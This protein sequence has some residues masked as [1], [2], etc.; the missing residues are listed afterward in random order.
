MVG[1]MKLLTPSLL[2]QGA[3]FPL[4]PYL[5]TSLQRQIETN[6][7]CFDNALD[8]LNTEADILPE[9]LFGLNQRGKEDRR[10]Q[11]GHN[12]IVPRKSLERVIGRTL[13]TLAVPANEGAEFEVII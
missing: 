12:I 3:K 8:S 9:G 4:Q 6:G 7:T 10:L 5:F 1:S 13:P 11:S 2:P